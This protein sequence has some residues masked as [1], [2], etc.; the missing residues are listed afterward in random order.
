M[1]AG[2]KFSEPS[3]R[4]GHV[5]AS[6]EGNICMLGGNTENFA[7]EKKELSS[8]INCFNPLSES[9]TNTEI[10]GLPPS[11][12]YSGACASAGHHLYMYGGTDASGSDSTSLHQLDL[13]TRTWNQLSSDGPMKKLECGMVAYSNQLVLFGGYGVLPSGSIQPGSEF[14]SD[15][16]IDGSGWTNELHTYDL[17]EGE[18]VWM[19]MFMLSSQVV[20]V[21]KSETLHNVNNNYVL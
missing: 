11:G 14:A 13:M 6:V 8:S 19:C 5:S 21:G 3:P 2:F 4:W 12:L 18:R 17:K 9:W 1:A 16:N 20:S 7:M 10:S 15:G